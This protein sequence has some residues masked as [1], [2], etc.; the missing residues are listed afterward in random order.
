MFFINERVRTVK[1]ITLN[2]ILHSPGVT[3]EIVEVRNGRTTYSGTAT[4]IYI[5]R[6]DYSQYSGLSGGERMECFED[7]IVRIGGASSPDEIKAKN[8]ATW[9][10]CEFID[11]GFGSDLWCKHDGCKKSRPKFS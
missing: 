9:H 8:L 6:C 11:P 10:N 7:E 2:G 3:G 4:L 5:I 1:R